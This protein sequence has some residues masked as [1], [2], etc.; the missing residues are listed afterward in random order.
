LTAPTRR[1]TAALAAK[2]TAPPLRRHWERSE[3]IQ[4]SSVVTPVLDRFVARSRSSQ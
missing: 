2:M 4:R 3:A 1:M